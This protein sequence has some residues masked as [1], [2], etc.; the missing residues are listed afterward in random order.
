MYTLIKQKGLPGVGR[1]GNHMRESQLMS[2]KHL[3]HMP[4]QWGQLSS[5]LCSARLVFLRELVK[6]WGDIT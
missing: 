2:W 1:Q 4:V 6:G 5:P 3:H